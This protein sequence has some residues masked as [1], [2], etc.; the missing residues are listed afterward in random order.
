MKSR[1]GNGPS[2]P[3]A[4][5]L[6]YGENVTSLHIV[7]P[8]EFIS[9]VAG[10]IA[11]GVDAAVEFWMAQAESAL[12]DDNLTTLGRMNA[13]QDVLTNYKQL[14]GKTEL[15]SRRGLSLLPPG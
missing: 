9:A 13:A 14:T 2:F 7:V 10:E 1:C 8:S 15:R 4:P 3:H 6:D 11:S 5:A 12:H